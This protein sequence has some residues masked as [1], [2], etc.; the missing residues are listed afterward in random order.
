M[1]IY[2]RKIIKMNNRL[3]TSS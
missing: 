1:L 3:S 2:I